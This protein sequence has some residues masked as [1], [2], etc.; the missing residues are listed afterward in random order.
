MA[1]QTCAGWPW[2]PTPASLLA[3]FIILLLAVANYMPEAVCQRVDS[4]TLLFSSRAQLSLTASYFALQA[5]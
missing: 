1:P 4:F 3:S 5:A 2:L